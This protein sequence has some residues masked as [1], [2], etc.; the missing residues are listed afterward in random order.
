VTEAVSEDELERVFGFSAP[1]PILSKSL[2]WFNAG[3]D[4]LRKS[5]FRDARVFNGL[6]LKV[7]LPDLITGKLGIDF[8]GLGDL[9]RPEPGDGSVDEGSVGRILFLPVA[10]VLS[11]FTVLGRF[12]GV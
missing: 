8:V 12:M 4:G 2:D 3:N 1:N 6:E 9:C 5:P 11:D 7:L 10:G